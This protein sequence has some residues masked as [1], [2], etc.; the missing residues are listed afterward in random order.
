MT[1][2]RAL[3][4]L[5]IFPGLLYA[6]PMAWLM[7]WIYRKLTASL[8]RR[9]GPPFYQPFF[10]F[11]KLLAKTPVARPPLQGLVMTALPLLAIG[12]TLGAIAL[13]PVLPDGGFAGDL[14]LLVALV[15]IAPLCAVLAGFATRSLF[16][17]IGATREAVL[18]L[19]YNLPFLTALFALSV[20][21][22]SFSLAGLVSAP[23][24]AVRVPALIALA[25]T[26][27]VKLHIN[28]FSAA[29]AEQEI[30]TG[31]TTEYDGPRLALW[32]LAHALEW[33]VLTGLWASLAF[34]AAA[35]AWPLRIV[36][37]VLIT[38]ALVV[39][40]TTASAA[41]ARLR[42]VQTSRFYWLW[43]FGVAIIA[44]AIALAR[45]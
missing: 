41:T 22:G 23:L 13:L 35:L 26:I 37:F 39:V 38:L 33:V 17:G 29:S 19:A 27:P 28:P 31:A 43:G 24:W 44:L 10:D 2:E 18:V 34:P 25:M 4:G 20:A 8:Q 16:G 40:L 6:V 5:L 45:G 14:I 15:E 21:T 30:Y 42:V 11:V 36:G 12:A 1:A 3:I 7:E 32:E 9:I